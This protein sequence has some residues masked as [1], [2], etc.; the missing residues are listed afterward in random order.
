LTGERS[1][2]AKGT[3]LTFTR[4]GAHSRS[5]I[6]HA[7]GDSTGREIARALQAKAAN[8]EINFFLDFE[9]TANLL[10]EAGRVCG[11]G[12]VQLR[13]ALKAGEGLGSLLPTGGN[14][15]KVFYRETTNPS[16]AREMA[17]AMAYRAGAEISDMEVCAVSSH[18]ALREE[19]SPLPAF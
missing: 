14:R 12:V 5:R 2:T 11:V 19:R 7:H 18:C 9:F 16:V 4:E 8:L 15:G 6:L 13:R 1:S 17:S 3:T 10:T